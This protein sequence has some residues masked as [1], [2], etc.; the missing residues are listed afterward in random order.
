[1]PRFLSEPLLIASLTLSLS[2]VLVG[3]HAVERSPLIITRTLQP[4][5]AGCIRPATAQSR[6]VE[7]LRDGF[8]PAID[9]DGQARSGNVDAGADEKAW[10]ETDSQCG[11]GRL[12]S[13]S[14]PFSRPN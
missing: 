12:R 5:F 13:R 11:Q 3:A 10:D 9:V 7:L 14:R 4:S 2:S 8:C 6:P 1:M